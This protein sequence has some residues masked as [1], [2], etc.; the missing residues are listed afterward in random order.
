MEGT[1]GTTV[2]AVWAAAFFAA[3]ALQTVRPSLIQAGL[4]ISQP[5]GFRAGPP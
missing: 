4:A 2:D 5:T 1:D 3:A